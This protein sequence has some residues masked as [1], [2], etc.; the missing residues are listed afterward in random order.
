MQLLFE[1]ST[2]QPH[3]SKVKKN[4]HRILILTGLE[5]RGGEESEPKVEILK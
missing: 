1:Y 2:E 3:I 4:Y 5:R